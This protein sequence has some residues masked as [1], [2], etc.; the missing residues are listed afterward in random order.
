MYGEQADESVGDVWLIQGARIDTYQMES[1]SI[2]GTA[3]GA[4]YDMEYLYFNWC[5]GGRSNGWYFY[6]GVW[7]EYYNNDESTGKDDP[8]VIG[9]C[10]TKNILMALG[11]KVCLI[12]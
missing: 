11:S 12:P 9:E 7:H 5:L 4:I 6:N 8:N 2:D 3:P 1:P 10:Y